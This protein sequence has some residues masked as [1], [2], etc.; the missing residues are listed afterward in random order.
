MSPVLSIRSY[1]SQQGSTYCRSHRSSTYRSHC[2]KK[3]I[4]QVAEWLPSRSVS[5]LVLKFWIL[6]E[7]SIGVQKI[8]QGVEKLDL[9]VQAYKML[10]VRTKKFETLVGQRKSGQK[11]RNLD[12]FLGSS[13]YYRDY[14]GTCHN[15]EYTKPHDHP[16]HHISFPYRAHSTRGWPDQ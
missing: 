14:Q 10:D 15:Y 9:G 2:W 4:L 5:L 3:I 16:L 8:F 7:A 6:Q 12:F 13:L 1:M 11:S